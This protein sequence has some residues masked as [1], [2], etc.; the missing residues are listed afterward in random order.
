[1]KARVAGF[2]VLPLNP[3]SAPILFDH[4]PVTTGFV[5]V[6]EWADVELAEISEETLTEYATKARRE[7]IAA[8]DD[9]RA[10]LL[11]EA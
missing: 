1:M 4:E 9:E 7:R 5:R 2:K 3:D 11:E 6:T 10:R 8:I